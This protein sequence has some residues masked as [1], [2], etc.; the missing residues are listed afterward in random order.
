MRQKVPIFLTC[1]FILLAVPVFAAEQ[2][3]YGG[4]LRVALG[5]DPPGLDVHLDTTFAVYNRARDIFNTLVRYSDDG[6][7]LEPELLAKLPD[8]S[9]DRKTFTFEL[10]KGIKAHDGSEL[11]ASDVKFTF[12]RILTPATKSPNT[13][14]VDVI[15]GAAAM[16]DGKATTLSGFKLVD[17][18][19]FQITL[20]KPYGPFLSHLAVPAVSIYPEAAFKAAGAKWAERPVGTG[21]FKVKSWQRGSK[22]VLE[23][24]KDYFEKGLPYLDGIEFR[25]IP[26]SNTALLEFE[27]GNL[28][29]GGI[30][31]ADFDRITKDK[32]WSKLVLSENAL[33]TYFYIFNFDQGV[34]KNVR[35]RKAF[36]MAFDRQT[37]ANVVLQGQASVAK[38]FVGPGI[39]GYQ[40][41]PGYE[42]N[43]KEARRLLKEAGYPNGITVESWLRQGSDTFKQRLEIMQAMLRES[44]IELKIVLTDSAGY[45][46]A[47]NNGL[48]PSY[49]GNWYAD[50]ADPDN[51]LYT[52]FHSSQSKRFSSNYNNPKVDRLLEEAR[53]EADPKERIRLY[54]AAEWI[55]VQED[56]AVVPLWHEKDFAVRQ[57]WVHGLF[58]HPTGINNA[59]KVVWMD[60]KR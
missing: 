33:N 21:P 3:T 10:R 49:W 32:K 28:D 47:R 22:L 20:E 17:N 25:I 27:A 14:W 19:R 55:I 40:P 1:L 45:R 24:H 56:V 44:G 16:L 4:V 38:A 48:I 54:Q 26:D 35:V 42:Y 41:L 2:P 15:A 8:V 60:A 7:S 9:S 6:L 5:A 37:L 52:F 39:P 57:P 59:H 58:L 34:F 50:F 36:A 43:P 23:K 11:T 12:E 31:D 30:P 18:Y 29:Y 13:N 51:Y 53:S 46:S